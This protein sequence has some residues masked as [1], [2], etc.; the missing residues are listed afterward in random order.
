MN[1]KDKLKTGTDSNDFKIVIL[2]GVI[3]LNLGVLKIHYMSIQ[4]LTME[5]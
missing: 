2:L 3:I 4:Y 1:F 5:Y